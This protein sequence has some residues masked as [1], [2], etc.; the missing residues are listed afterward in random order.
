MGW[1]KN[2]KCNEMTSII[3]NQDDIRYYSKIVSDKFLEVEIWKSVFRFFLKM[4]KEWLDNFQKFLARIFY[5]DGNFSYAWKYFV[6]VEWTI[7]RPF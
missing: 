4:M 6:F 1:R 2:Q 5:R 7:F 3:R